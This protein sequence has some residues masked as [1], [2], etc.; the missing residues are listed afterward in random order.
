M[1]IEDLIIQLSRIRGINSADMSII[2]S[3]SDQF[4]QGTGLT[5]KQSQLSLRILNRYFQLLSDKLKIDVSPHLTTPKFR[6]PLRKS[7]IDHTI[8]ILDGSKIEVRF[9][10]NE[11]LVNAI[12]KFKTE[13]DQ[14][15][16]I[17]WDRPTTS[18]IFNLSERNI[19]FLM[20]LATQVNFTFDDEF[21]KYVD[22]VEDVVNNMEKYAPMLVIDNRDLKIANS[23]KNMPEIDTDDILE[24]IFQAR[25]MG[26]TLWDNYINE[27][28]DVGPINGTLKKFL[29]SNVT[30]EFKLAP[31]ESDIF[32]LKQIVKYSGPTLVIIPG[33]SELEK[34]QTIYDILKGSGTEDKNMSVLFRLP[35]ETDKKFNDFVKNQGINGPICEETKVVFV[36]TKLPK[37]LINSKIRFN[38][39]INMGYAMAH[40]SL[41]QYTKN[42]QN[43]INFGVKIKAQGFNFAEL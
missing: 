15:S 37:P 33:G 1:H 5:E 8:K 14:S 17:M 7:V 35:N 24:A 3:F 10:Y 19:K 2:D 43:F 32:A 36:S 4:Y 40:Y 27:Y 38:N 25:T 13:S 42:H 12:R 41:K 29:T 9:A 21:Q 34:I 26:V 31:T 28:L 11:T 39:V 23:P 22:S 20:N 30:D 16:Q 18:W 6:L